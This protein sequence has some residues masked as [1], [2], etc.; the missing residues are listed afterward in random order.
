MLQIGEPMIMVLDSEHTSG[1]LAP[2]LIFSTPSSRELRYLAATA[3]S[4]TSLHTFS[5]MTT[6]RRCTSKLR[7]FNPL[8]RSGTSM[9]SDGAVTSATNVVFDR[10]L[11]VFATYVSV[12][13]ASVLPALPAYLCRRRHG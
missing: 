12:S 2:V 3:G 7:S 4:R 11:M 1:K 6:V 9:A 8:L 13:G 10:A 5:V